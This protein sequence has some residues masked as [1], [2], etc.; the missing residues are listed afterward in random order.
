M[1]STTT[2]SPNLPYDAAAARAQ[3][4]AE[5]RE[6]APADATEI[7]LVPEEYRGLD[8]FEAR[9]KVIADIT[10]KYKTN[11]WAL[12]TGRPSFCSSGPT[13]TAAIA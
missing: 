9:T 5:G 1:T 12:R 8:R 3:A 13:S 7:N 6:D 2:A 4:I 10:A 11:R